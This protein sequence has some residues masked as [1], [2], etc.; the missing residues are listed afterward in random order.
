MVK[1]ITEKKIENNFAFLLDSKTTIFYHTTY[2]Y[3]MSNNFHVE[4]KFDSFFQIKLK[5]W[6]INFTI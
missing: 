2:T 6:S 3:T 4:I 5:K 1:T